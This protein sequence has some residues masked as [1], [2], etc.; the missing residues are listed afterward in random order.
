MLT[1]AAALAALMI[2]AAACTPPRP[3]EIRFN[4]DDPFVTIFAG[5]PLDGLEATYV[6]D[7]QTQTCWFMTGKAMASLDCCALR[8][9]NTGRQYITWGNCPADAAPAPPGAR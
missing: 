7:R 4:E 1:R 8:R 6:I 3:R 9:L 2:G 5:L